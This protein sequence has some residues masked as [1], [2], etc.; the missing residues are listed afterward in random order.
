ME[1]QNRKERK[2]RAKDARVFAPFFVFPCVLRDFFLVSLA[3]K[4][5]K[6]LILTASEVRFANF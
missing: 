5:I 6:I 1:M 4:C 3:D 2:G